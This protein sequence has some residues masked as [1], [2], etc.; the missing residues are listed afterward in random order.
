MA[1]RYGLKHKLQILTDNVIMICL[2]A[3]GNDII[4]L[5]I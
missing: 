1:A 3:S 2:N 5:D 4:I